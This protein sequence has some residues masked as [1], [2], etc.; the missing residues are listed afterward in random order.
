MNVEYY[1]YAKECMRKKGLWKLL[2]LIFFMAFIGT[3]VAAILLKR[4]NDKY[5]D[6]LVEISEQIPV[7][8]EQEEELA[9]IRKREWSRANSP[10][11]RKTD[12][13]R[14]AENRVTEEA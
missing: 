2:A 9:E 12:E 14:I 6:A 13:E 5:K 7:T 4:R 10:A 3:S 1:G 11:N 8:F